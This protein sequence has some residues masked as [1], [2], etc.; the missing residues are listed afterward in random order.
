ME[1]IDIKDKVLVV[2]PYLAKAAQGR[3]IEYA[4]AGWRKYFKEPYHI[5]VVGDYNPV[6]DTGDDISFI[7][8]PRIAK[9]PLGNYRPHLDHVHKFREVRKHFPDTS[10]FVYTCDDIYAV[11]DFNLSDIM[12][13]K[14]KS[15]SIT[16]NSESKNAWVRDNVRTRQT[17]RKRGMQAYNWVCHLPV[18][19]EWDKLFKIYDEYNCDRKSYVVEQ[20][21]F[22][23][24]YAGVMPVV[25]NPESDDIQYRLN[26]PGTNIE[27][28]KK[29][30]SNKIWLNNSVKGWK[31]EMETILQEYYGL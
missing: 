2:I 4:V 18:Y 26:S 27:G 8:C 11:R 13:L 1:E 24:Y 9:P 15:L 19:Y 16:G 20:L 17:L 29:A 5:V 14:V 6:V 30:I 7:E 10:G 25:L 22:N 28:F 21:Y 23:T 12:L 31:P 3:E